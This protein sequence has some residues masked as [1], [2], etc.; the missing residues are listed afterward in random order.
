MI[1]FFTFSQ[2][3]NKRPPAGSTQIRVNQLIKYWPEAG[4][5]KYGENP[6][7]LIF[8][9]VYLTQDYR[10]PIHF[11]GKKILDICDP[12][13]TDGLSPIKETIDAMD[14]VTC[15]TEAMAEF[16]RQMTDKPVRV[17]K[18]R[19]DIDVLPEPKRHTGR[20]KTVV[21]FGYYHNS[22]VLRPALPLLKEHGLKLILISN[23][24]P[25]A[26]RWPLAPEHRDYLKDNYQF[27]KY[28]EETIY[29]DLQKADIALL[30]IGNRPQ[31]VFKSENKTVKAE[32]AG[33]PVSQD[34]ESLEKYLKGEN[35]Q[36]FVDKYY[37]SV[38]DNYDVR[39]SVDE[40]KQL[41]NEL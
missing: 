15:P 2:F 35:R 13:W 18:D 40:Y 39:K 41:I 36:A 37:E 1:R 16:L 29:H 8:Q 5:Y 30:P 26:F 32:L 34:P 28:N 17:I 7:V 33:L 24:D 27:I 14:A 31:D 19:F 25:L 12:D 4:L 3:H 22:E 38:R 10:F 9:K 20:A 6:D 23:D 11:K 21:W